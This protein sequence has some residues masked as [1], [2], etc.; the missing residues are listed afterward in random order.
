MIDIL[1]KLNLIFEKPKNVLIFIFSIIALNIVIYNVSNNSTISNIQSRK[2]ASGFS[3]NRAKQFIYFYY[4][5]GNF[6]LATLCEEELK[7]SE[8]EAIN[9]INENGKCLIMEYQHWSRLGEN[10]RIFAFMPN[11]LLNNSPENASLKLFNSI[12]FVSSLLVLFLGFRRINF[13][14]IGSILVLILNSTPFFLYEVYQNQNIFALLGSTFFII[15]GLNIQILFKENNSFFKTL[16]FGVFSS[17]LIAFFTEIRN[18]VS[19]VFL[20]FLLIY[21]LSTKLN[22]KRKIIFSIIFIFIF[23]QTRQFIQKY[24]NSKFNETEELVSNNKGHV[25]EGKRISGHKI[26]HPIFCG[27]GDFDTKYGYKWND[28]VAYKYAVPI[29]N[30]EY[31]YDFTYIDEYYTNKF[32]DKDSIYYIKYDEINEYEEI[33]KKKV[34]SDILNDPFWYMNIIIKRV[35]KIM[36][37]TLPIPYM[38]WFLLAMIVFLLYNRKWVYFKLLFLSLPLSATSLVIYSG[39]GSTYNSVFGYMV[40]AIVLMMLLEKRKKKLEF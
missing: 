21:L 32:Y 16:M 17:L 20:S 22:Y 38:G 11:A 35:L 13:A 14:I 4:Y 39:K 9:H 1:V 40:I 2:D 8:K 18:E 10:A 33:V 23:I 36:S 34:I 29:L 26:W 30:K 5:T 6:P 24:F 27:L 31:D 12:I 25:Y 7:F 15:L 3:I 28:K 19:I 37:T